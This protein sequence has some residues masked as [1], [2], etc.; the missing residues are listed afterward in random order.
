MDKISEKD[1][2]R[3]VIPWHLP[4]YLAAPVPCSLTCVLLCCAS[5][6]NHGHTELCEDSSAPLSPL[7]MGK[8]QARMLKRS[9]SVCPLAETKLQKK[10]LLNQKGDKGGFSLVYGVL[11]DSMS[12]WFCNNYSISLSWIFVWFSHTLEGLW[13]G[14]KCSSGAPVGN[15]LSESGAG[16]AYEE[17]HWVKADMSKISLS[18]QKE[19]L[20]VVSLTSE[21]VIVNYCMLF[22]PPQGLTYAFGR[23]FFQ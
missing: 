23:I 8:R 15:S 16:T 1:Y 13:G 2:M 18:K 9:L 19:R 5:S 20:L 14:K 10:L 21:L 6:R 11:V 4:F 7:T 17:R 22:F 12:L 3:C